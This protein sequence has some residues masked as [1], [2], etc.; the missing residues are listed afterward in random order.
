MKRLFAAALFSLAAL[1]SQAALVSTTTGMTGF[2][3]NS[4]TV[5]AG[6]NAVLGAGYTHLKFQGSSNNDGSSYSPVV[7]FSTKAGTFGGSNTPKV[8]YSTG[9][10]EIGP[11]GTWDGIL[12]IDFL[13]NGYTVSAVG[14]GLVEFDSAREFIRVYDQ[15]NALIGNF[16]DALGGTFSLW[17]VNGTAGERIGRIELDGN[18]FAIQD[19]A[20]NAESTRVSEPAGL[21]LLGLGLVGLGLARRRRAA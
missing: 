8:N 10:G 20:F 11:F 17:G 7:T 9:N 16:N 13:A 4:D 2:T 18:F 19:I 21:A 15:N 14:F 3:Y 6:F 12:N 5:S 1:S